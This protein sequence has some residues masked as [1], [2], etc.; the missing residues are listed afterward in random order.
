MTENLA[1]QL[2][3]AMPEMGDPR[4]ERAVIYLCAH[5][6]DGTMGLIV[7]KPAPHIDFA[8]LLHQLDIPGTP[9]DDPVRFGGPVEMTRG[10]V[11]HSEEYQTEDSTLP[12]AHG[13]ALSSSLDVLHAIAAGRG[14]AQALFALGYAGWGAGQLEAEIARNDWLTAP[15]NPEILFGIEDELKWRAALDLI[16]VDPVLLS[17]EAGRA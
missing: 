5:S 4:F 7:N 11:L 13:L 10:F 3:I 16:G 1:G 12:L 2:L 8:D 17:S 6:S 9:P 15:A 14:P